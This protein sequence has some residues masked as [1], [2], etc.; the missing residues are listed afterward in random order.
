M[1]SK[2]SSPSPLA[3][4]GSEK[5]NL[6]LDRGADE[7][8]M[9]PFVLTENSSASGS[10][11]LYLP[12]ACAALRLPSAGTKGEDTPKDDCWSLSSAAPCAWRAAYTED[13]LKKRD[14][15]AALPTT[16]HASIISATKAHTYTENHKRGSADLP[17]SSKGLRDTGLY[18]ASVCDVLVSFRMSN[19]LFT[20]FVGCEILRR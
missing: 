7:P 1:S 4:P 9:P 11:K 20:V 13:E 17:H 2:L 16:R 6:E 15:G 5:A 19:I 3:S 8:P 14:E 18:R 12:L 10:P